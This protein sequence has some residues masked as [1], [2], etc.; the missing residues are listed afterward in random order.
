MERNSKGGNCGHP[1]LSWDGP[2]DAAGCRSGLIGGNEA[3]PRTALGRTRR[4]DGGAAKVCFFPDNRR[5]LPVRSRPHLAPEDKPEEPLLR[6]LARLERTF[7]CHPSTAAIRPE[8]Q[9]PRPS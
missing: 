7:T 4:C 2:L 9:L 1:C 6:P 3:E 5:K 8:R